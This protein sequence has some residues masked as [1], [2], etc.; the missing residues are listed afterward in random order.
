MRRAPTILFLLAW[1]AFGQD[2]NCSDLRQYV[3]RIELSGPGPV[4]FGGGFFVSGDGD[5]VTAF[6]LFEESP[7]A[8][9][10][11]V[12]VDDGD[13]VYD[14]SI[15]SITSYS[16]NLD[17][18]I[19]RVRLAGAWVR[20]PPVGSPVSIGDK[21][22]GFTVQFPGPILCR[23]GIVSAIS[24]RQINASGTDFFGPG[25]SGS[26]V[27]DASGRVVAI[28]MEMVTPNREA[29]RPEYVYVSL[30]VER[31]L[32]ARKLARPL[33]V[34]EFMAKLHAAR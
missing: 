18:V 8:I 26:P 24:P 29:R 28:A 4:R 25:S 23:Q 3:Y 11:V 10:A 27:F 20:T 22:F 34:P 15:V 21:L 17:Y 1:S 32:K 16:R 9:G 7:H 14:R 30:P 13:S 19:G 33:T 31:A 2:P 12:A 6:H 5:F